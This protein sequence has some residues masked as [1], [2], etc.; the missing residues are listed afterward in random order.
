MI[1]AKLGLN[2]STKM[3]EIGEQKLQ[4]EV[5]DLDIEQVTIGFAGYMTSL[6]STTPMFFTSPALG[7][8]AI[9]IAVRSTQLVLLLRVRMY[10][11]SGQRTTPSS[12]VVRHM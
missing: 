2:L 11:L 4:Q 1:L 6:S 3:E 8:L 5:G 10:L 9:S 7:I 12:E